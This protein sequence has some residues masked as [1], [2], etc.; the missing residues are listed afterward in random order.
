MSEFV[1]IRRKVC[2]SSRKWRV[3]VRVVDTLGVGIFGGGRSAR[4]RVWWLS[5]LAQRGFMLC[6]FLR[7]LYS[8]ERKRRTVVELDRRS[9]DVPLRRC[10]AGVGREGRIGRRA[11]MLPG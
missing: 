8:V 5:G 9:R 11:Y 10:G 4:W 1:E 3:G 2:A 7:V 6:A